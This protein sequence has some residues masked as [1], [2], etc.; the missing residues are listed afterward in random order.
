MALK[1]MRGSKGMFGV[2]PNGT[3]HFRRFASQ[4]GN[5]WKRYRGPASDIRDFGT[6][7]SIVRGSDGI[8]AVSTTG[9]IAFR[10]FGRRTRW[11]AYDGP[12]A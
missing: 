9:K 4:G 3:I 1:L 6:V 8:F 5:G 7:E 11:N 2:M 10:K 12:V